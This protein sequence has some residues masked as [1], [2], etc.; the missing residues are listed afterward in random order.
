MGKFIVETKKGIHILPYEDILFMEKDQKVIVVY[1]E[2]ERIRFYGS[3]S[4]VYD[5]LDRRFMWCHRS[6]IINMD[7]IVWM[8]GQE[9]YVKG[10]FTIH[11]GSNTY[12]K[13]KRFFS[14]YLDEKRES[15]YQKTR[16]LERGDNNHK[17]S[18]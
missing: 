12:H 4:Q 9:I 2:K 10:N 17:N 15:I 14:A 13:A 1:T 11:L 5:Q 6:Y 8:S 7:K 16:K 3:F 18:A